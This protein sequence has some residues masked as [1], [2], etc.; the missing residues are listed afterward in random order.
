MVRTAIEYYAISCL[1]APLQWAQ[2]ILTEDSES[3]LKC[4]LLLR[5][6]KWLLTME[7]IGL[8]GRARPSVEEWSLNRLWNKQTLLLATCFKFWVTSHEVSAWLSSKGVFPHCFFVL[9]TRQLVST[10]TYS[11]AQAYVMPTAQY[12][13]VSNKGMKGYF[14]FQEVRGNISSQQTSRGPRPRR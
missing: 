12:T 7:T 1:L 2:T 11:L 10:E 13:E 5:E 6:G 14:S 8:L 3:F 4:A 9:L